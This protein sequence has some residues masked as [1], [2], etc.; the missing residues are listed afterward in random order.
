[1]ETPV[2]EVATRAGLGRG[3]LYRH[4]PTKYRLID[5]ILQEHCDDHVIA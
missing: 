5:A 1:V 3:T 4:F 2:E